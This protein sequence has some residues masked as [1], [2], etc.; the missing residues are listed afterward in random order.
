M[1]SQS[2]LTSH[3]AGIS[4][5]VHANVRHFVTQE[6]TDIEL[7][8]SWTVDHATEEIAKAIEL[9]E[10]NAENVKQSYELYVRGQ[11]GRSQRLPPS[12]LLRDSVR[13]GDEIEPL[14]EI[15]PGAA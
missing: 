4:P 5:M 10:R 7:P 8:G 6:T 15:I 1:I 9:P 14:P 2:Q 13:E 12:A 3:E 11:D